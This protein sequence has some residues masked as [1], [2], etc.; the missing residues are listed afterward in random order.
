MKL[1][2]VS[3]FAALC[4]AATA[5]AL[6]LT[7][8]TTENQLVTF[9]TSAPGTYLSTTPISGLASPLASIINL[10]YHAGNGSYYGLDNNANF[11]QISSSGSAVLLNDTFAP[12]GFSGGLAYD[13]FT[14][15]LIFGTVLSEHFT[16]TA[17]GLASSNPD[18]IYGTGDANS[19]LNPSVFAMA[20]D[21]ITGEAFFLD[22]ETGTLSQSFDPALA[23]L[24]TT[25]NLGVTVTDFG[26]LVVDEDGNLFASLSTDALSSSLYSI[27]KTTG[28]ATLIGN[29][30]GGVSALAI[31]E[32]SAALLSGIG[33]LA[34]LRRRRA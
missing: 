12:N 22:N 26:A 25:G 8:V 14:D 21:P 9:D 10:T 19:A 23:E 7:G 16:L 20:I 24:F 1:P 15:N 32:P 13:P 6:V 34:L 27:D 4:M 17:A 11:Y 33:V 5:P 30:A 18:F 3:A 28:E 31:P 2:I 29:F